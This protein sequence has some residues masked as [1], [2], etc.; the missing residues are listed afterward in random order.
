MSSAKWRPF[1][2]GLN[3]LTHCVLVMQMASHNLVNIGSG[4]W[5][6]LWWHQVITWINVDSESVRSC[7]IQ[8]AESKF[9]GNANDIYPWGKLQ[10]HWFL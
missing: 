5:F 6:V 8:L 1:C 3:V 10:N 4:K 9:K 2:L 7:D